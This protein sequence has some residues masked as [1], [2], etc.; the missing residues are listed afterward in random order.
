MAGKNLIFA[1]A[2]DVLQQGLIGN[3][4]ELELR[5]ISDKNKMGRGR[6]PLV[7]LPEP[8]GIGSRRR[9]T[10]KS[11]PRAREPN[12]PDSSTFLL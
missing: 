9:K 12:P 3:T 2:G 10:R 6:A 8:P 4:K 11:S 1:V 7:E 5:D